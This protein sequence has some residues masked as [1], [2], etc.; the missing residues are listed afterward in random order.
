MSQKGC[1]IHPGVASGP[2]PSKWNMRLDSNQTVQ[3]TLLDCQ[4]D[5]LPNI[6][7]PAQIPWKIL[8]VFCLV[9][10][11]ITVELLVMADS[12]DPCW[13]RHLPSEIPE[14]V[15]MYGVHTSKNQKASRGTT[16]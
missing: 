2:S 11:Q 16:R 3:G 10:K 8:F 7:T 14:E 9:R 4:A 5:P 15:P 12:L 1:A 13:H 6:L